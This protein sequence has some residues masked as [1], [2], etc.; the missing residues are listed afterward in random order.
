MN[1]HI[2]R[3]KS[4]YKKIPQFCSENSPNNCRNFVLVNRFWKNTKKIVFVILN[5]IIKLRTAFVT[6][7]GTL[8]YLFVL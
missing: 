5:I 7:Q 4:G 8:R 3:R 6:A 2:E 1:F